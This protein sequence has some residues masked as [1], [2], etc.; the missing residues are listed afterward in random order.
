MPMKKKAAPAKPL[1]VACCELP[2]FSAKNL[3]TVRRAFENAMPIPAQQ[4]W[5]SSLEA[6]FSPMLVQI[7]WRGDALLIFAELTDA[8]IFTRA[9]VD[10]Q[11]FWELGDSFEIFLRPTEQE[12][13]VEFQVAPNNR[14]LQLRYPNADAVALARKTGATDRFVIYKRAFHSMTWTHDKKKWFVFA[15]VPARS[16][17]KQNKSLHGTEWLFSFSRYDY[18][19]GRREPVISSTSPHAKADFHRQ[20]EWGVMRFEECKTKVTES[21]S[22]KFHNSA[23]EIFVPDGQ[24]VGKA[25]GRITHLGIGAHQDDLEF[26]AFHGILACHA[27]AKK[28]FGGVTC[29][30][31]SGSARTGSYAKFTD[32]QM[33]AVRR[34]EQDKAAKVG[35]YGVMIQLDYPSSAVK[36]ARD[37]A[38]KNDLKKILAAARPEIVYTHNPADKHD[39]HIGVVI[40]ALQA[41]RELPRGQR[42][43]RVWGCEVWRNLDWL[44]DGDKVLM[45]VS[46]HDKLAKL[47]NGIFDSQ[48]TGGKRYDLAIAGRRFANATFF[49]SHSADHSTQ[50]I[51]GM[52]L[53]PLVKDESGDVVDYVTGFI[54]KFKND[55]REKLSKRLGRD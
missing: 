39:T 55:V 17:C 52:D 11:R 36:S 51:Y 40:A 31:G 24:P 16:V 6:D 45:D 30:N 53:T 42:P 20:Q 50:L 21:G 49:D 14:R 48:I 26:M 13:Y 47:L 41:M 5:R 19:R 28:W 18:T 12:T 46:S 54:D 22:M 27:S 33:M 25:I 9:T 23:A 43:K 38:L 7:G 1:V 8:D 37:A 32:A 44:P 29:T 10:N 35:Y 2:P 4:A 15:E 34:R 3:A